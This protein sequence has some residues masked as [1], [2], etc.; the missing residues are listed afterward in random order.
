MTTCNNKTCPKLLDCARHESN[1]GYET[2]PREFKH[3]FLSGSF[4]CEDFIYKPVNNLNNIKMRTILLNLDKLDSEIKILEEEK[5][6]HDKGSDE[7]LKLDA[8]IDLITT[9]IIKCTIKQQ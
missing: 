3:N 8:M 7:W 9:I 4:A 6:Q 5:Q 1:F 2:N